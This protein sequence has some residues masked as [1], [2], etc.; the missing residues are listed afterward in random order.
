MSAETQRRMTP[1]GWKPIR[2]G[3]L[4]GFAAISLPAGLEIDDVPV[5]MTNGKAWAALPARPVITSEGHVARL[6]GSSKAQYVTFLRWRDRTLSTTFRERVVEL[7]R[8][9][10]SEAFAHDVGAP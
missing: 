1:R 3:S 10:D 8:Q 4:I 9:A 5:L 2:K 6:P 7:V